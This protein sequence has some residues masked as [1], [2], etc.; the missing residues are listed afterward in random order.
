MQGWD[1]IQKIL[2]GYSSIECNNSQMQFTPLLSGNLHSNPLL[3]VTH[4]IQ[5]EDFPRR[6]TELYSV[7][8]YIISFTHVNYDRNKW[9]QIIIINTEV[10]LSRQGYS[11]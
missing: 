6:F 8:D 4:Q 5:M 11:C 3:N 7:F 9:M 2:Y 1:L 10:L